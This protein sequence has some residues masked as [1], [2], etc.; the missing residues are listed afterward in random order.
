MQEIGHRCSFLRDADTSN[1]RHT[2]TGIDPI[3]SQYGP[4]INDVPKTGMGLAMKM[5]RVLIGCVSLTVKRGRGWVQKSQNFADIIY[6]C[7]DRTTATS[8]K[9]RNICGVTDQTEEEEEKGKTEQEVRR[10]RSV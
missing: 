1:I 8:D 2:H 5:T 7:P 9:K 6:E 4:S 3:P 10:T